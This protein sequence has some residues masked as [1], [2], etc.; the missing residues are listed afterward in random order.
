[1]QARARLPEQLQRKPDHCAE[2]DTERNDAK[3]QSDPVAHVTGRAIMVVD[4][5][6]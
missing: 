2:V 4:H 3:A 5:A 1:M 6:P